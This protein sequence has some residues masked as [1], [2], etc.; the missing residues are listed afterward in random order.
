MIYM[1]FQNAL[2]IVW[3]ATQLLGVLYNKRCKF[4]CWV[5]T[6]LASNGNS[7]NSHNTLK[8]GT[9]Y[10][11]STWYH[12]KVFP[13]KSHAGINSKFLQLQ[14][15]LSYNNEWKQQAKVYLL[16][17]SLEKSYYLILTDP[18]NYLVLDFLI[19]SRQD[20]FC[21]LIQRPNRLS[22]NS[23]SHPI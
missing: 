12:I 10:A 20:N 11:F 13:N 17:S 15:N 16:L 19:L 23:F 22:F 6:I 4:Y 14:H 2:S 8:T 5:L 7:Y 9:S 1:S 18:T 21:C 3:F